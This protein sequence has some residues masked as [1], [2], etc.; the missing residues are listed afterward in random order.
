MFRRS[1]IPTIALFSLLIGVS[2]TA[3]ALAQDTTENPDMAADTMSAPAMDPEAALISAYAT[4]NQ[5]Y[6]KVKPLFERGCFDCHSDKTV[7]PWYYKLPIIKG[8]IDGDIRKARKHVDFTYGF[9][10]KGH[11]RP[12]DDLLDIR[13]ELIEGDMPPWDYNLMHWSA[14]PS[15]A[16]RDT[17][18]T[19]VDSSLRLLAAHGQYPFDRAD[20]VPP[21]GQATDKPIGE[22]KEDED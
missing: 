5:E 16:E 17:I 15:D 1:A 11:A 12:A 20:L 19:W 13:G 6:Q 22:E 21:E 3:P 14:G 7:Y 10:F 9:P 18:I 4:I 2:A 8:L